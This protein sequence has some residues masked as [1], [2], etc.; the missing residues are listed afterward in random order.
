MPILTCSLGE[1][2]ENKSEAENTF[3]VHDDKK[4]AVYARAIPH[5]MSFLSHR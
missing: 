2:G 1:D 4:C 5:P 3:T